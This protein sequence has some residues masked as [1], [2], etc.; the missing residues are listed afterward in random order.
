MPTVVSQPRVERND[1][2][3]AIWWRRSLPSN[4]FGQDLDI[5]PF[6]GRATVYSE[7][8]VSSTTDLL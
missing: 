1:V 5:R 8:L 2:A 3:S 4:L 6:K 7:F